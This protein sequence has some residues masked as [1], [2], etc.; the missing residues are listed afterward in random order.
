MTRVGS[1][2][3]QMRGGGER[4][5]EGRLGGERSKRLGAISLAW[6]PGWVHA[7]RTRAEKPRPSDRRWLVRGRGGVSPMRVMMRHRQVVC[8]RLT[9]RVDR[10]RP[11]FVLFDGR[12]SVRC[13]ARML[14][15]KW[16]CRVLVALLIIQKALLLRLRR[17]LKAFGNLLRVCYRN[18]VCGAAFSV[19]VG[20][21]I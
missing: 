21:V 4:G 9:A 15:L 11:R 6:R 17:P 8:D 10:W 14:V 20:A 5:L 19:V 12:G 7:G 16:A 18:R 2:S 13:G 1:V 3:D